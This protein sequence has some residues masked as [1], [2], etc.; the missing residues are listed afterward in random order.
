[1]C[2]ATR[3]GIYSA[4]CKLSYQSTADAPFHGKREACTTSRVFRPA[5]CIRGWAPCSQRPCTLDSPR[6]PAPQPRTACTQMR[7]RLT[8]AAVLRSNVDSR[9]I[10]GEAW[11]LQYL[12]ASSP[13][14][15]KQGCVMQPSALHLEVFTS[16]CASPV[17][18]LH[19]LASTTAAHNK[20]PPT[21]TGAQFQA[22]RESY[23]SSRALGLISCK[24]ER[25]SNSL[26]SG[27]SCY[28]HPPAKALF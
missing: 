14:Q 27:T 24:K 13:G 9:T 5:N 20:F 8:H 19:A 26:L 18:S 25:A 3:C 6:R 16:T 21:P 10:P 17:H 23:S 4:K 15:L 11:R 12:R 2:S 22:M 28:T 7:A 1:M